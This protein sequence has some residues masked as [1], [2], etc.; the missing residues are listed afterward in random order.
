MP[1]KH[2]WLIQSYLIV[3]LASLAGKRV[4]IGA[5]ANVLCGEDRLVPDVIVVDR[6]ARYLDGDLAEPPVLAVEILSP[7]Q[8]I[9]T[10]FDKAYRLLKAGTPCCWVI[11]PEN[12]QAWI[13][14]LDGL[15]QAVECLQAALPEGSFQISLSEMWSEL[16]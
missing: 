10:L 14:K 6:N 13:C 7:G 12:R 16:D 5:E 11:W 9:G 1:K 4:R 3:K 2:Y 8:S 15:E